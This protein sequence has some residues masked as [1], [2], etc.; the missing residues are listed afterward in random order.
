MCSFYLIT[1][2]I[3]V[4]VVASNIPERGTLGFC[5]PRWSFV[6]AR[7]LAFANASILPESETQVRDN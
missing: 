1:A 2:R 3:S 6:V 4:F 7:I 5:Y